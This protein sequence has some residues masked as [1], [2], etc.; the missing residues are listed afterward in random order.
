MPVIQLQYP[1]GALDTDRKAALARRL[2]DVMLT[3]EGGARTEGGIAFATVLFNEVPQG[4]WWVGGHS[5]DRYVHP[6]GRFLARVSIPEGYMNRQHKSEVHEAVTR[7]VL[8]T[9]GGAPDERRGASVQVIIEEVIEGNWGAG[10]RT[11]SLSS[12][13]DTV[14]QP[15]DGERFRWV[16]SYFAAKARQ[17]AAAGYPADAGGL[18]PEERPPAPSSR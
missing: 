4:D 1:Q 7:A 18:L 8:D 17:F 14:G 10:G 2:T 5:D 3:M 12:I 13:A 9:V 11:I 16:R 6:P 15:K